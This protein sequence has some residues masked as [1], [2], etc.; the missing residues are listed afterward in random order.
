MVLGVPVFAMIYS[1]VSRLV[2]HGLR[3]RNLPVATQE[4]MGKT[5]PLSK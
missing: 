2:V 4:Y 3:V 5:K 1:V